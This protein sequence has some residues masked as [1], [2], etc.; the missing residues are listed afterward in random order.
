VMA[1][2]VATVI[3]KLEGDHAA[4]FTRGSKHITMV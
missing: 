2:K 3:K 4:C 1:Y